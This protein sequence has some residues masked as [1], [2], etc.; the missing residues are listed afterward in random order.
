MSDP[1]SS[2]SEKVTV[3]LRLPRELVRR[4]DHLTVDLD[5]FRNELVER[6]LLDGLP[7]YESKEP[8]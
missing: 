8:G 7:K 1:G 5:L 4:I 3:Q 6:V 2:E